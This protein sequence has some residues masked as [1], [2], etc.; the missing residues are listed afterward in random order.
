MT[1]ITWKPPSVPNAKRSQ[2]PDSA[3]AFPKERKEPLTDANHVR[4]AIARFHQ[5][6]GVTEHERVQAEA[7]ISAAATYYGVHFEH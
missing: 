7:N 6:D 3:F 4:S 2:L 1:T 5:V